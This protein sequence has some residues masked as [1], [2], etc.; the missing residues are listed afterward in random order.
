MLGLNKELEPTAGMSKAEVDGLDIMS[1]PIRHASRQ[2]WR[3]SSHVSIA[4]VV[5]GIASIP[6]EKGKTGQWPG[7]RPGMIVSIVG[8]V[9]VAVDEV[10]S[11]RSCSRPSVIMYI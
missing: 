1:T 3:N 8:A 5:F 9:A 6:P 7:Q 11:S 2:M 10:G 4:E